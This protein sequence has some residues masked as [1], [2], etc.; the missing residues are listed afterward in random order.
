MGS[1]GQRSTQ[2]YVATARGNSATAQQQLHQRLRN[3]ARPLTDGCAAKILAQR[4]RALA[5]STAPNMPPIQPLCSARNAR[6]L[7]RTIQ[8]HTKNTM[9]RPL[10]NAMRHLPVSTH[11]APRPA[12]AAR[13]TVPISSAGRNRQYAPRL[14]RGCPHSGTGAGCRPRSCP[15]LPARPD[16]A[17]AASMGCCTARWAL[18][19]TCPFARA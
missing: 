19:W 6:R 17:S 2:Q 18:A 11:A 9:R 7:V 14:L 13:H 4:L 16:A 15:L 1:C 12:W 8:R 5:L 10:V 3:P